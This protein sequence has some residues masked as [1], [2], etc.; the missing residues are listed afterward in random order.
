[1]EQTAFRRFTVDKLVVGYE[2]LSNK[3]FAEYRRSRLNNTDF[4]IISNNCWGG[5]VYRRYGLPY[6]SPTVGMYFYMEE[7][8]R[9]LSDLENNLH[10]PFSIISARESKYSKELFRKQQQDV[11][12]GLIGNDIEVVLLHYHKKQEA[13]EKWNRRTKRVNL[14]NLIVK[15]SEM[16]LCTDK[17][18]EAFNEMPFQKKVLLTSRYHGNLDNEVVVRHYTKNNQISNDTLYYNEYINLEQL[19]NSPVSTSY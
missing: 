10:K 9:F 3:L 5:S 1:M 14:N 8:I 17:H 12:V 18:L 19:I 7:Y 6:S 15:I 16:N 2:K 13:I 11:L 4:S